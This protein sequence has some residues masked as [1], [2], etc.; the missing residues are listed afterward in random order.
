MGAFALIAIPFL[1]SR[2]DVFPFSVG[3]EIPDEVQDS[4]V[5]ASSPMPA[6]GQG[7]RTQACSR[8]A[9]SL[10]NSLNS[11]F[12]PCDDFYLYVCSNWRNRHSAYSE[13]AKTSVDDVLLFQYSDLVGNILHNSHSAMPAAK[14]VFDTCIHPPKSLF[15]AMRDNL[16]YLMR[17][18]NWPYLRTHLSKIS[19]EDV[20]ARIGAL[21]RYL[22]LDSLFHF[23]V[24]EGTSNSVPV[25]GEPD[26][27]IGNFQ[28]PLRSYEFL[29]TAFT[30]VMNWMNKFADTDVALFE[31]E[32]ARRKVL[33]SHLNE[34]VLKR[35]KR[36]M[37]T[38][39]PA[40]KL[41]VW[42]T[43]LERAFDEQVMLKSNGEVRVASLDYLLS[44]NDTPTLP[45]KSDILNYIVFRVVMALSPLIHNNTLRRELAS[46]AYAAHPPFAPY[47][48]DVHY[49]VRFLD[50]FEPYV[51]MLLAYDESVLLVGY[52]TLQGLLLNDLKNA[53]N[54]F[55]SSEITFSGTFKNGLLERLAKISWE[56]VVPQALFSKE[57][58]KR[59]VDKMYTGSPVRPLND[60]Y[61][62][63]LQ[64]A[65]RKKH[66]TR[67]GRHPITGWKG[68]FLRA[69]P[70]L[71]PPF[72]Q[73]EIPLPV[74]DFRL[75]NDESVRRLHVPRVATRIYRTLYQ[76]VYTWAYNFY[77]KT[78]DSDPVSTLENARGCLRLDY[79]F[80]TSP[81]SQLTLNAEATSLMDLFDYLAIRP[82]FGAFMQLS[83]N[84]SFWIHEAPLFSA[85]KLF[86]IYYALGYCEYNN[87]MYLDKSMRQSHE[88]PAWY[89]VNG[90]LR[91]F[92]GFA[93]AFNCTKGTFMNPLH[94][95]L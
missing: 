4:D 86:F 1:P 61:F 60:F 65:V 15:P 63:W 56:P 64:E 88:S 29:T 95:C 74:F 19:Q 82:A 17:V 22:G 52:D 38:D 67:T 31:V 39:L 91:H 2:L 14:L 70:S 77:H 7:C 26:L 42:K 28:G 59:Y 13:E 6:S 5:I 55:L 62:S 68:G 32:L 47:Q 46:L 20:S 66:G 83:L 12:D 94:K 43:I 89:K 21:Y 48:P 10:L 8:E 45:R 27:L 16:L 73:M 51:P 93:K 11:S 57:F 69:F 3:Q 85:E 53:F 81:F 79:A 80:L 54:E 71:E 9:R 90:P 75:P 34:C 18:Q 58:R 84:G 87:P 33:A 76:F 78:A 40:N 35:C 50:R 72:R 23:S 36:Q 41:V 92:D 44:F 25:I 49:C 37:A 30:S 24:L